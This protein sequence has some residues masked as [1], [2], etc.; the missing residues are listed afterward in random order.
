MVPY[1]GSYTHVGRR[2]LVAW[3]SSRE[4]VRALNDA[5]PLIHGA[6]EVTLATNVSTGLACQPA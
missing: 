6:D 4:A 2:V 3:D 1:I 5:L